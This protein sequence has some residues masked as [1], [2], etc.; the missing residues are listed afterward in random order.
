MPTYQITYQVN[1]FL[2]YKVK[3]DSEKDAIKAINDDL[4]DHYDDYTD[5]DTSV[6][7]SIKKEED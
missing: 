6:I 5:Y 1:R 2:D 4:V 3:A 7:H